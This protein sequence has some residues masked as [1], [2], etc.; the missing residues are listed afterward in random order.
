MEPLFGQ[1]SIL[2]GCLGEWWEPGG[3]LQGDAHRKPSTA[4]ALG[5]GLSLH[6]SHHGALWG[7]GGRGMGR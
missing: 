3:M 1:W 6:S 4:L 5:L 2:L 7:Q